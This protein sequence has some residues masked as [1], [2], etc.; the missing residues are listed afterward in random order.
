MGTIKT[1]MVK[2]KQRQERLEVARIHRRN[3]QKKI[4][5]D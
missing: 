3:I 4:T 2:T 5:N 1:K